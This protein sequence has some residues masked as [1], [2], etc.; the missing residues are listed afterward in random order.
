VNATLALV[1]AAIDEPEALGALI[2]GDVAPGW[3]GFPDALPAL[4]DSALLTPVSGPHWGSM[5][6]VV[7]EPRTLVGLGGY[8]GPPRDGAVE[9]GYAVA[10]AFQQRGLA[11]EAARQLVALAFADP[12]VSSVQAHTM[13][14]P[15]PSTRVLE[16]LG[17]ECEGVEEDPDEGPVWAWR[18]TT[19]AYQAALS[20]GPPP[21]T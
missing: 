12:A 13:P 3:E 11:T 5:L 2:G 19:T 9:I 15:N 14:G 8:Y 20:P 17:F 7:P 21:S 6:F 4:V 1:R 18:L 16:R 10:P